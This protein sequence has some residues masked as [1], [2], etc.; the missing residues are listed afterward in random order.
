MYV[1]IH[2]T[3][4]SGVCIIQFIM[5]TPMYIVDVFIQPIHVYKDRGW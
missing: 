5:S 2:Y 3:T 4:L 1:H